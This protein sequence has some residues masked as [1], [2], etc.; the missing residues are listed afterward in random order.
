MSPSVFLQLPLGVKVAF[1]VLLWP[2]IWAGALMAVA[3]AG[4]VIRQTKKA[5]SSSV[6]ESSLASRVT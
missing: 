4:D 2:A 5:D 1:V 6:A 3:L